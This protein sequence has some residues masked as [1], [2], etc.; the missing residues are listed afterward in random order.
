M[1]QTLAHPRP[2]TLYSGHKTGLPKL[3]TLSGKQQYSA[4]ARDVTLG[5]FKPSDILSRLE[6][7]TLLIQL[8]TAF[9]WSCLN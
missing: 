7:L 2:S 3:M 1:V 6:A 5:D 8:V 4:K 9:T